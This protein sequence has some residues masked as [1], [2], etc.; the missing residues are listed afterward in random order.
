M[1]KLFGRSYE[2]V[3]NSSSDLILKC[4]G[5]V[6]VKWGNKYI[7]LVKDGKVA[8]NGLTIKRVSS[9]SIPTAA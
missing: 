6:K 9:D 7:D 5:Q 8:S 4:R 3:G 2:S 1:E